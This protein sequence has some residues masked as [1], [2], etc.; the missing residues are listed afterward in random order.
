MTEFQKRILVEE[1]KNFCEDF[2]RSAPAYGDLYLE[3]L[4]DYFIKNYIHKDKIR[5]KL[6]EIQQE[7]LMLGKNDYS[8]TEYQY[9]Q[10]TLIGKENILQELLGE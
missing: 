1:I 9:K 4:L 3:E 6:K 5:D 10:L 2:K 7:L 8:V